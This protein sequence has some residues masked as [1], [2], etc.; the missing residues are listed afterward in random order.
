MVPTRFCLKWHAHEFEKSSNA[1]LQPSSGKQKGRM[2]QDTKHLSAY[3]HFLLLQ[4]IGLIGAAPA[5]DMTVTLRW[6]QPCYRGS[7]LEAHI[8]R[9]GHAKALSQY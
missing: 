1:L 3:A 9:P 2:L 6:G 8:D 5:V 4:Q 7:T